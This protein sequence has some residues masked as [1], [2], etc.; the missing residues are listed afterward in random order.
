MEGTSTPRICGPYLD[1]YVGRN[2]M[3][4]GKVVQLRGDQA[5]VDAEGNVTAHL[6]RV[7]FCLHDQK[8]T[9]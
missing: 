9:K 6:N 8:T 2:V 5:T 3:V 7:S 1:S 4:I